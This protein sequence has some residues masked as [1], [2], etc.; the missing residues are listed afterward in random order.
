[1]LNAKSFNLFHHYI[2]AILRLSSVKKQISFF[3]LTRECFPSAFSDLSFRFSL[4]TKTGCNLAS[5]TRI[6]NYFCFS[7]STFLD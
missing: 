2:F 7:F 6:H 5:S 3:H 4:N 1:M